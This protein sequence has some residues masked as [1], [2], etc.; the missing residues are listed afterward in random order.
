MD[1]QRALTELRALHIIR[2][3]PPSTIDCRRGLAPERRTL[4]IRVAILSDDRLFR[5]G[6]LRI[7]G[8]ESSLVVVGWDG[9]APLA[10]APRAAGPDILIVDSRMK[11]ALAL[12]AEIKRM[13]V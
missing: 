10:S 9:G 6:L 5:E 4:A 2:P 1:R 8:A 11:G 3:L 7:V 13:G 12:C